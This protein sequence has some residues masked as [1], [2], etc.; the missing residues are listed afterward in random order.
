MSIYGALVNNFNL[1]AAISVDGQRVAFTSF[2]SNLVPDDTNGIPDVFVHDLP[3]DR[4]ARVLAP[5]PL[6]P[7]RRSVQMAP[8]CCIV[9]SALV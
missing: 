1:R 5:R 7:L 3:K 4:A 9:C 8:I 6:T 2:A